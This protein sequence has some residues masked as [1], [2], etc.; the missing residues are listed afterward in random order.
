[1]ARTSRKGAALRQAA[2]VPAERMWNCAVYAR[3]SAE[4]GGRKGADTIETQIELVTSYVS[5]RSYLSLYDTY[6][7][8]GESGKDFDRPAWQRLMDDVRTGRVDCICVKD[9]SRFSRNYIET[10]EFLE[11]IFPFMGVRFVSVNDGYDNQAPG[12]NNEGLIIALKSLVNDQYLKDISRKICSS[13]QA[14]RERGEYTRGFAPFGYMKAEGEKGRLEPD[15]E[16]ALVI[17]DIFRWRL[18]GMSHLAICKRLDEEGIPTPNEYLRRKHDNKDMYGSEYF[19]SVIWR[20]ATLKGILRSPVY[21]GTVETGKESQRLFEHKPCT[22]VPREQWAITENAHEP[23][24]S[25]ELWDAVQTVEATTR[26]AY[27]KSA[28]RPERTEN[29]F[30]GFIIC[31][32]CGSKMS[33]SYSS[34]RMVSG[35]LWETYYYLCPISRQHS[36][37]QKL[38]SI[39]EDAVHGVVF[40][41]VVDRLRTAANLSDII[42]KRS[43]RQENPR[44]V[45]DAEISLVA[46]ELEGMNGKLVRLYEDFADK[47]LDERQYVQIKKKYE[48]QAEALRQRA[49]DLSQRAAIITDVSASNNRWLAAARSFQNPDRLTREMLEAIVERIVIKDTEHIE[50]IWSF[51]DEF[52]LLEACASAKEG[53]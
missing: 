19:K 17:R 5:Q 30:K 37:E 31:G 10:I 32:S 6:I 45:I 2:T 36:A 7:D 50:V 26:A 11:K 29:I 44:A 8:N 33:R 1:M 28:Q 23:I 16:I 41:L 20:A 35:K 47:I 3:L 49:D 21:I 42:V 46:R 38:R 24:V 22:D 25:R 15:P 12:N 34:K 53:V 48:Q 51:D 52:K 13:V 14:K 27:A 43:R 9:L 18:D 4:D 40:P 39:R